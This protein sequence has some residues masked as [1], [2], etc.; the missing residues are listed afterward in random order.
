[1]TK[2]NPALATTN[3][4]RAPAPFRTSPFRSSRQVITGPASDVRSA[5]DEGLSVRKRSAVQPSTDAR[6]AGLVL[7]RLDARP[8][9]IESRPPMASSIADRVVSAAVRVV[10]F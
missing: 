3:G 4:R 2:S 8:E 5:L 7:S 6:R 9:C 10:A 1:M